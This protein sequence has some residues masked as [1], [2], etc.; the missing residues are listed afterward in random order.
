MPRLPILGLTLAATCLLAGVP[1]KAQMESREAIAL[2]NQILELRHDLDQLR[3]QGGVAAA[4]SETYTP[5]PASGAMSGDIATQLLDRVSRLED[6]VREL[7][8]RIDEVNNARQRSADDLTK[9]LGDLEFRLNN[10]GAGGAVTAP[11]ERPGTTLNPPT[12]NL[13]TYRA[14]AAPAPVPGAPPVPRRTPE[15]ALQAGD[16][17]LARRDYPAAEAAAREVLASGRGPRTTDAQYLLAQSLAGQRNYQ[18]AAVAYDDAYNR[19]VRGSRAPDSL[20][21]VA[22]SLTALGDKKAAC[23]TLDK[24]HAEFPSPRPELRESVVAARSRAGCH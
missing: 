10:G 24:L 5:P 20:L 7:R 23:Q 6:E 1:V 14:P 4:P 21:G 9:Q 22:N 13:G 16:A 17:A 2:Q 15:L 8:G 11:P 12:G 3:A 19:S 18:A